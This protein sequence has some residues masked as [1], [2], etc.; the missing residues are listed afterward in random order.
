M[1]FSWTGFML[2]PLLVPLIV[3]AVMAPLLNGDG[4]VALPFLFLLIAACII[5]H[6]TTAFLFLPALFLLSLWRPVTAWMV[7]TLGFL[8]GT[9]AILP[10][11]VLACKGSG[12][13]SGPPVETFLTFF[14]RWAADPL[15]AIFPVA[16]ILTSGLYWWL[17]KWR[18]NSAL[19]TTGTATR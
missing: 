11:T 4:P 17:G 13:D 16:G 7:S 15:M 14:W 19:V 2:A 8:L 12:P 1:R 3:S 10:V 9:A 18:R 6:S 5:S